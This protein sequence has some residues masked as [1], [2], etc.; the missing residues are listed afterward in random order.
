MSKNTEALEEHRLSKLDHM[1]NTFLFS[2]LLPTARPLSTTIPGWEKGEWTSELA[3]VFPN[4]GIRGWA[5]V[6][7]RLVKAKSVLEV[8][9]K[10]MGSGHRP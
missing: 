8:L 2:L 4:K 6:N 7:A 9:Q 5:S 3:L 1:S 10:V